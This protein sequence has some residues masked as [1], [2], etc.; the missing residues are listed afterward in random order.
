VE[1]EEGLAHAP[2]GGAEGE[3]EEEDADECEELYVLCGE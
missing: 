2:E 3:R 1:G